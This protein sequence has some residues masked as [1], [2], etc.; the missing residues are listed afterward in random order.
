[1]IGSFLVL[2]AGVADVAV[3]SAAL[4]AEVHRTFTFDGDPIPPEIFGEFGDG[5]WQI[6]DPSR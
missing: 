2:A 6:P 5:D 1:M 4:I 3:R